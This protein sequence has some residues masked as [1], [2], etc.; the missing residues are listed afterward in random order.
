MPFISVFYG[1]SIF[2]F[3]LTYVIKT[4]NKQ[5]EVLLVLCYV[6]GSEVFL[7]MTGGNGLHELAK[8]EVI[9]FSIIGMLY[10]GFSNKSAVFVICL[11]LIVPGVII[12]MNSISFLLDVR[13]AI[14]FNILGPIT[15]IISSVYCYD[16]VISKAHLHKMLVFLSLPIIATVV[17]L[18]LYTPKNADIFQTT[19]SNFNTSGGFGPNQVSTILGLGMFAFFALFLLYSKSKK[20]VILNISILLI[21]SYRGLI[22]FSRGGVITGVAMIIVLIA[23]SLLY[24]N[25]SAKVKVLRI[26]GGGIFAFFIVW[27]YSLYVTDGKIGNRYA[28]QDVT[29]RVKKKRFSGRE[30]ITELE[31]DLF[32]ENPFLGIGVGKGKEKRLKILGKE[33]AAHNELTRMISEHGLI[34]VLILLILIV[35]PL[36]HAQQNKS[37]LVS[38]PFFIFWLLTINHAAMR[39]AAPA[40]IYSLSL[41]RFNSKIINE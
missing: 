22:T 38:I 3:G 16:K 27:S 20:L 23:L 11:L 9:L 1:L 5:N 24:A 39:L 10:N 14:T 35:T 25:L 4:G 30:E 36:L 2:V 17:Y 19:Q 40:F 33:V 12:G 21:V 29:G 8:Y 6:I 34:G 7:R 13:K 18:F 26:I 31:V 28:N 41:L 32:L 37:Y 15:L